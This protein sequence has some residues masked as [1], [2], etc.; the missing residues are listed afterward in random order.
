MTSPESALQAYARFRTAERLRAV[1]R[2]GQ[3]DIVIHY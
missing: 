3:A 2:R 1:V